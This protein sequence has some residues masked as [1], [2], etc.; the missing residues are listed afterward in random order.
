MANEEYQ[1]SDI[2]PLTI[3][4]MKIVDPFFSPIGEQS[5]KLSLS[6]QGGTDQSEKKTG[7]DGLIEEKSFSPAFN[8]VLEFSDDQTTS[9]DDGGDRE[10]DGESSSQPG[11]GGIDIGKNFIWTTDIESDEEG[12]SEAEDPPGPIA[13]EQV[14]ELKN[15]SDGGKGPLKRSDNRSELVKHVQ[16]MLDALGFY[17][18]KIDGDFGPNTEKAVKGFQEKYKDWEG[19]ALKVDGLVGPRTSDALNRALVGIW[20]DRYETPKELTEE[21]KLIAV[22]KKH[23]KETGI[24]YKE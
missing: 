7:S 23:A 9:P 19:D 10:S 8:L 13:K 4:S 12:G 21:T 5:Y 15:R 1:F 20:Y 3:E 11:P 6:S 14:I 2:R 18:G 17:P 22:S 24:K 16:Q